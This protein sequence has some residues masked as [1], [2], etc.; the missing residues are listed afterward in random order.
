MSNASGGGKTLAQ[1]A[2]SCFPALGRWSFQSQILIMV[3]ILLGNW[4]MLNPNIKLPPPPEGRQI[5]F[6]SPLVSIEIQVEEV[7]YLVFC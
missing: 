5:L 7:R 1:L 2:A 6:I 4:S 3:P